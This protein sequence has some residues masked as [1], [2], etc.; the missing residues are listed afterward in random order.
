MDG[1]SFLR[2]G[3]LFFRVCQSQKDRDNEEEEY[4]D[5]GSRGGGVVRTISVF[6]C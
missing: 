3:R 5:V 1:S 6:R 2:V 4:S